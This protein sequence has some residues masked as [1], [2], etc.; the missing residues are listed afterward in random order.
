MSAFSVSEPFP[1]FHDRDGQ[2]LDAGYLYFGTA[3]LPALSSPIPVYIDAALTIPAAQPVRTLNGFPQ[4]QG[5]A[6][7]LYVNADDF[8][9]AV[10]QSDNTLVFSSLNATVRIPFSAT[11]GT[12]TSDRVTYL[13]GGVGST[14]RVLTS[15]LQESVS[16]FDFMTS[17]QVADVRA[18]TLLIDVSS[19]INAAIAAA[20]EVYFPEGAYRVSN[21]GTPTNGAIDI[22]NGAGSKTLRGAGRGNAIIHNYGLGPCITS[23]GNLL[24]NNVSLHIC[25]L[26]IQGTVGSGDGIFCDYTS[27]SMFERLELYQCQVSGIKIQRGSHNSLTDIWSRASIFDGVFIGKETYFTNIT[28]GTFESNFRHGL[29]VDANGGIPPQDVTVTGTSLRSNA[30]HNVNVL[31][32]ASKVRLFGC[33]LFTTTSDATA[34]H[35]SVDGGG[36]VSSACSATGCSFAGQNSSTSVVGIYGNACEDLSID[37]CSIDCT[38]SDAYAFTAS[39]LRPRVLDSAI[40]L[41]TTIS[42]STTTVVRNIVSSPSPGTAFLVGTSSSTVKIQVPNNVPLVRFNDQRV[43]GDTNNIYTLN[44]TPINVTDGWVVGPGCETFTVAT[45][46]AGAPV[47]TR[48]RCTNCFENAWGDIL[49]I[50]GPWDRFLIWNGTNWTIFGVGS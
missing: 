9:V 36:A 10:H 46:P 4:Y 20:D 13:E 24:F 48:V 18:G 3:G 1:T 16:V 14:T 7:R 2:P 38:G 12:I 19:A 11:T 25:D 34:R 21:D 49:T 23:I 43:W 39:A 33:F 42:A 44:S 35:L 40:I 17:A 8:S 45:L 29:N 47:G 28:G 37:G 6:C 5:A 50:A 31:D 26:T 30:V 41:G 15:K 22:P 32:G 27:Q